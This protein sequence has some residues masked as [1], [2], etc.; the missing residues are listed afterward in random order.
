MKDNDK[1][2]TNEIAFR[3]LLLVLKRCWW[4]VLAVA[5]VLGAA[6]YAFMKLTHKAEYTATAT[7]WAIG[8]NANTSNN[9]MQTSTYD[10]QIATYLIND[11]KELITTRSVMEV[12][13]ENA[14]SELSPAALKANTE[15]TNA[16]E[17][18]VMHVSV[19]ASDPKEAQMLVN[20]LSNEFCRRVNEKNKGVAADQEN[21]VEKPLVSVWEEAMVPT[22][23]SN[24]ISLLLVILIALLGAV[25]VYVVFLVIH[26]S[27]DKI[28]TTEDVEKYLGLTLL[29]VIPNIEDSRRRSMRKKA[30]YHYTSAQKQGDQ[31]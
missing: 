3:D 20:S 19:T 25:I 27:D 14:K 8:S 6:S 7:I 5:I 17:S 21:T 16:E 12:A 9:N 11:Y 2:A 15:I 24:P 26:L 23:I 18:R 28:N 22:Q 4:L 1:N 30:Y 31:H 10:V 13:L 29:G